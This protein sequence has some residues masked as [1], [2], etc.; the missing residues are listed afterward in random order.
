[1]GDDIT[2]LPA[3]AEVG[4]SAAPADAV[5]EVLAAAQHVTT[6]GGGKGAVREVCDLI[7]A[8]LSRQ[9]GGAAKAIP[10]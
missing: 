9:A 8:A 4:F 1:M 7:R 6:A 2:D 3:F 10:M 5:P